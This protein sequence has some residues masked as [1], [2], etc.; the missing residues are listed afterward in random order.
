MRKTALVTGGIDGIG[1]ALALTL[2]RAD[3]AVS[4]VGQQKEEGTRAYHAAGA[5]NG[6]TSPLSSFR[7]SSCFVNT[8]K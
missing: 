6:S 7:K 5:I 3:C 4:I 8:A 1:K 2:A